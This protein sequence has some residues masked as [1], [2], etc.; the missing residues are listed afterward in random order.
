MTGYAYMGTMNK[1]RDMGEVDAIH[2]FSFFFYF[3]FLVKKNLN[4][5]SVFLVSPVSVDYCHGSHFIVLF[6][7]QLIT[8]RL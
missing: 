1:I 7:G 3:F 2:V 6:I 4:F 8:G 5:V